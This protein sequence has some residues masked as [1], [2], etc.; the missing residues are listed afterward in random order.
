MLLDVTLY[1]ETG[2]NLVDIPDSADIIKNNY[3]SRTIG[4]C[5]FLQSRFIGVAKVPITWNAVQ[6]VDYCLIGTTWYYVMQITMINENMCALTLMM[7]AITTLE[8][9]KLNVNSIKGWLTRRHVKDDTLGRYTID[10][11]FQPSEPL[12]MVHVQS[13]G[14]VENNENINFIT[15]SVSLTPFLTDATP[16]SIRFGETD[17]DSVVVPRVPATVGSGNDVDPG[18]QETKFSMSGFGTSNVKPQPLPATCVWRL[19]DIPG[20][21]LRTLRSIG[22]N[23]ITDSYA[24]PS[25]YV[26]VTGEGFNSPVK[27]VNGE[28]QQI[29]SNILVRPY[30]DVTDNIYNAK[31]WSG[32]F[33]KVTIASAVTGDSIQFDA[34]EILPRDSDTYTDRFQFILFADP[35]PNGA[36]YL[37]PRN[38]LG[39][40]A[41]FP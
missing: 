18:A 19:S 25:S 34:T 38:Y 29:I 5:T 1:Y 35:T 14:Q 10:E 24:I 16:A 20:G 33:H 17:E 6:G 28:Q 41:N 4:Q 3:R 21:T 23:L 9:V 7:D 13:V 2:F 11:P 40:Q 31:V 15:T 12:E 27:S 39:I 26:T 37:R 36:P 32:Q 30:L 8:L 22:L